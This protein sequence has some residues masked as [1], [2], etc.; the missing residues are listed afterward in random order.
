M[1]F[2]SIGNDLKVHLIFHR[3]H[4]TSEGRQT[5]GADLKE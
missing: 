2:L 5:T 1:D 4:L 3:D